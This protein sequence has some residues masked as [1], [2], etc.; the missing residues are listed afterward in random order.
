M[1]QC[2][3]PIIDSVCCTGCGA[4]VAICPDQILAADASGRPKIH[5]ER[6][7]LCGH[8]AAL[9]PERA[10]TVPALVD[11][12]SLISVDERA[13]G[14]APAAIAPADLVSLM[15]RRR[16]CRRFTAEPVETTMLSDLAKIG[17]TAPSGTN[18]QGWSFIILPRRAD[19]ERLGRA[20]ADFYS[21]LNKMAANPWY[22]LASRLFFNDALN[23]YYRRY[24]Q[25]IDQALRQWREERIDRLFH[26]APAAIIVTGATTASCPAEDALLATQSILLAAESLGLG[27]CLI[28]FVVEAAR[29]DPAIARLLRLGA[30]ERIHA[31]IAC[32]H[33]AIAF[34]RPAGRKPIQPRILMIDPEEP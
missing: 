33:P 15:R 14:M 12:L 20:T 19:V 1:H 5:G 24:Y 7:M 10:I 22:R 34:R 9:C 28:G 13:P 32:G 8:C 30:E 26:G 3:L 16:S 23:R 2:E 29:R 11:S 21:R 27:T 18:S 25:S 6:C 17:T 4:C 31:V